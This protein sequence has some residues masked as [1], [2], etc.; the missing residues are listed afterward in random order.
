MARN[1]EVLR[2]IQEAS[3]KDTKFASLLGLKIIDA[4]VGYCK[5]EMEV[6]EIYKNPLGTVH[7]GCL[8]TLAD[9]IG[10]FAAASCGMIGPTVSGSMY[11]L[12]PAKDT[13][14]LICEASIMKKGKRIRISE[15][16]IYG[17]NGEEIARSLIEYMDLQKNLVV[18]EDGEKK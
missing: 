18:N 9:T 12:R 2:L 11:F 13:Q 14:R 1:E 15:I 17:D 8:Y 16:K 4:D 7:G 5:A 6:K 3:E 10:G